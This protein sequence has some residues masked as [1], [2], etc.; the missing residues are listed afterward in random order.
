MSYIRGLPA[1]LITT[2]EPPSGLTCLKDF[3]GVCSIYRTHPILKTAPKVGLGT[4]YSRS[5]KLETQ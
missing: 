4:V 3:E 2:H 1:P 5:P